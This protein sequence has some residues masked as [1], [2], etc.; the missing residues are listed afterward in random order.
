MNLFMCRPISK[1]C[2]NFNGK[3]V[4]LL[5]AFFPMKIIKK[6]KIFKPI[7]ALGNFLTHLSEIGNPLKLRLSLYWYFDPRSL[8]RRNFVW[9]YYFRPPSNS[10][11]FR[12]FN[13]FRDVPF[14]PASW[15]RLNWNIVLTKF[16]TR[17]NFE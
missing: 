1:I 9:R 16:W 5:K 2:T 11:F 4:H 15:F 14:L 7:W 13:H 6:K 8:G 17:A 3:T 12:E 10:P